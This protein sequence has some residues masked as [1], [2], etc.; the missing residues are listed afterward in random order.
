MKMD[1]IKA[2]KNCAQR[3][4]KGSTDSD[5]VGLT[6]QSDS[7]LDERAAKSGTVF[8]Y[9]SPWSSARWLAQLRKPR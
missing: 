5:N 3:F 6:A 7:L 8:R 9:G 1:S 4:V 2:Q